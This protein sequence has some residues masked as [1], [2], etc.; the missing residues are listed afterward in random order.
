MVQA[1]YA[2]SPL[3]SKKATQDAT[4]A[5]DETARRNQRIAVQYEYRRK[6]LMTRLRSSTP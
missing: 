3:E 6:A 1:H 2:K 5:F 4:T